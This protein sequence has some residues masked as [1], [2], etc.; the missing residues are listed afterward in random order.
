[1][2]DTLNIAGSWIK[3]NNRT[4]ALNTIVIKRK[5]WNCGEEGHSVSECSKPCDEATITKNRNK[6]MQSRPSGNNS[7]GG[8]GRGNGGGRGNGSGRGRGGGRGRGDPDYQRKA[9]ETQGIK[10]DSDG[11]LKVNCRVCGLNTTH[12]SRYHS[13]WASN[14]STFRLP[15]NNVYVKACQSLTRTAPKPPPTNPPPTPPSSQPPGQNPSGQAGSLI[16]DRASLESK[17]S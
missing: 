9:W 8:R 7:G 15:D 17:M 12:S 3:I 16:L 6:F 13:A 1:M 10:V 5:C 11:V 4:N 14:P 2:Y